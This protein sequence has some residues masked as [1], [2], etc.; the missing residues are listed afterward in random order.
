MIGDVCVIAEIKAPF[1]H[2]MQPSD[3]IHRVGLAPPSTKGLQDVAVP[4]ENASNGIAGS[5]RMV[6]RFTC[7][8]PDRTWS[9]ISGV[10]VFR[11]E[12]TGIW[13]AALKQA[14]LAMQA[15]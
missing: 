15:S 4:L 9:G 3:I 8:L 1:P 12:I 10:A 2:P 11:A 7:S 14:L 13:N 5:H 6:L